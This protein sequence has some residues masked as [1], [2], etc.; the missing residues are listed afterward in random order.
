M[1]FHVALMGLAVYLLLWDKLPNWG[2]WFKSI[3][4]GLP[5]PVQTLYRQWNCAYC[6]GFWIALTLH[7]LTGL[8][9]IP[10]LAEAP[11]YMGQLG[12][13]ANWFLDA[14]AGGTLI[15]AAN[16]ALKAL[17]APVLWARLS[18]ESQLQER[19]GRRSVSADA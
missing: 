11:A 18:T 14:L 9:T 15:Y 13:L 7:A 6:S 16:T 17:G 2:T 3:I 10:A 8:W 12:I 19:D 5:Q 4:A 1:E